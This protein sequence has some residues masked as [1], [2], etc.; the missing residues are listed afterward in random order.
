MYLH[1]EKVLGKGLVLQWGEELLPNPWSVSKTFAVPISN[2][3]APGFRVIVFSTTR[4]GEILTDT[5]FL[6]V[7]QFTKH[8]ID[9]NLNQ[10]KDRSKDTV[11]L[12]FFGEP[13]AYFGISGQ[14]GM[15]H[16]M[17]AG[18]ELSKASVLRNFYELE[19]SQ[20]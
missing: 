2:E 18:N 9:M 19:P 16:L 10:N 13:G 20:K 8:A 15:R 6:P 11:E 4:T 14:R 12:R 5:I 17:H 7:D 3:M 1:C